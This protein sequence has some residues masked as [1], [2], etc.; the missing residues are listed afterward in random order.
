MTATISWPLS[1]GLLGG[2]WQWPDDGHVMLLL[3]GVR[4][5]DLVF[6]LREWTDGHYQ[7]DPLY[8]GTPFCA[9]QHLSPW[10]LTLSGPDDPAL[11]RFLDAGLDDEWGY[12]LVSQATPLAV[13]NHLRALLQVRCPDGGAPM[14]LRV[15]DPAVIGAILPAERSAA[16]S[17]WGPIGQ[18]IAPDGVMAQ[19]R[20]WSPRED[21]GHLPTR[22]IP[23]DGLRL[24]AIDLRRLQACDRRTDLRRLMRF[25]DTHQPEWLGGLANAERYARLDTLTREAAP[26]GVDGGKQWQRLCV[27]MS[28]LDRM[29][30]D[31]DDFP[32]DIR[33]I[34]SDVHRGDGNVRLKAAL[35][36][37]RIA[38]P[39]MHD[40][41]DTRTTDV[42]R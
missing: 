21:V 34:L 22:T 6:Q 27:L 2:E 18:L 1:A 40:E 12:L 30:L 24:D 23:P 11:R 17:P 32:A 4:V 13:A 36:S 8:A 31:E 14:L 28:R 15:A 37:L 16:E 38:E 20:S 5:R 7:G 3:D 33:E 25:V 19:W 29:S 35:A 39:M 10:L 42:E 41:N 26:L 9:V